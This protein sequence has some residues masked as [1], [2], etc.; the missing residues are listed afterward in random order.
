MT[1]THYCKKK[2][3]IGW[4]P[5]CNLEK[6]VVWHVSLKQLHQLSWLPT[7]CIMVTALHKRKNSISLWEFLCVNSNGLATDNNKVWVD[8]DTNRS[9]IITTLTSFQ[10]QSDGKLSPL[11]V[12]LLSWCNK[13]TLGG[14]ADCVWVF[15]ELIPIFQATILKTTWVKVHSTQLQYFWSCHGLQLS[16]SLVWL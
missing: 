11:T 14:A 1:Q 10:L 7:G 8:Y 6:L 3:K 4:W 5:P 16:F 9:S 12:L 13:F 2:K 15:T